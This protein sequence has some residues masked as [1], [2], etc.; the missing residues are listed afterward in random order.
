MKINGLEGLSVGQVQADVARGGKFVVFQYCIS[1][2]VITFRRPSA[3]YFIRS[4]QST[5]GKSLGYTVLSLVLGWWGL[6]WGP[7]YT[8]GA[9]IT[10]SRGG[11]DITSEVMASLN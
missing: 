7:I 3:I 10:N 2:L 5:F 11:K 8:I 6:P 4:N 1:V 9:L